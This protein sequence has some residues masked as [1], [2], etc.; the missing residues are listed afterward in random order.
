MWN[1]TLFIFTT[2][3]HSVKV[4]SVMRMKNGLCGTDCAAPA[5]NEFLPSAD[6]A[7]PSVSVGW[8]L[9]GPARRFGRAE[10]RIKKEQH[11]TIRSKTVS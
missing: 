1:Q 7:A 3:L 10:L 2:T 6:M 8:Q 11:P 5:R 9:V 4:S